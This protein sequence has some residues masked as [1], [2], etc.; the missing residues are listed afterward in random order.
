MSA[1]GFDFSSD[2]WFDPNFFSSGRFRASCLPCSSATA[3]AS[4]IC[5]EKLIRCGS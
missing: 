5:L 1:V 3:L 2:L 4:N